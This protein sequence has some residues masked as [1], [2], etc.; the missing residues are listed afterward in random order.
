M[1]RDEGASVDG[2]IEIQE[3]LKEL[4][5]QP[6]VLSQLQE[7]TPEV[8]KTPEVP[9]MVKLVMKLSGGAIKEQ[10]QAEY[11][12]LGLVVLMLGLSFYLFFSL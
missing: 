7:Q 4:E 8:S 3:A 1:F 9:K 6:G 10:K 11:V 5:A 12:L 2:N